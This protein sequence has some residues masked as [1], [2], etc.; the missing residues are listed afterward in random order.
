[1][2]P[3]RMILIAGLVIGAVW[4][5]V[6]LGGEVVGMVGSTKENPRGS[7]FTMTRNFVCRSCGYTVPATPEEITRR[8]EAG[9][10]RLAADGSTQVYLCDREGTP[11]LE[12]IIDAKPKP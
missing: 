5:V 8:I 9:Q 4:A 6:R 12:L 2:S 3:A 11:T 10:T 7:S 1:M